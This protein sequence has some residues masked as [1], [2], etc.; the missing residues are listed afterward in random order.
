[1]LINS[2]LDKPILLISLC[3]V[4]VSSI[5]GGNLSAA[6]NHIKQQRN[7]SLAA[8]GYLHLIA[9]TDLH[10]KIGVKAL[11]AQQHLLAQPA[12]SW[13]SSS[14]KGILVSP[15]RKVI[16]LFEFFVTGGSS[17]LA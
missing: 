3:L 13:N 8:Y 16:L 4:Y 6:D 15:L 1:M 17:I 5:A 12:S 11:G 10:K 2:K 7:Q 14:W 9:S